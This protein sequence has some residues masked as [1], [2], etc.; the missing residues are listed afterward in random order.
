[1]QDRVPLGGWLYAVDSYCLLSSDS[2]S[3]SAFLR[4]ARIPPLSCKARHAGL[5]SPCV[6]DAWPGTGR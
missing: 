4:V 5:S 2:K 3:M 1:M 6:A